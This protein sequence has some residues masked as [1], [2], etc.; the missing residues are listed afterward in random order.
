MA[1][2]KV[3]YNFFHNI[4]V[5]EQINI[6]LSFSFLQHRDHN[7]TDKKTKCLQESVKL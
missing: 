4:D 7:T 5:E 6:S 3:K 1:I 2:F